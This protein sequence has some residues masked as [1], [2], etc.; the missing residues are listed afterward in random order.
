[1]TARIEFFWDCVSSYTYIASTQIERVAA[2]AGAV[3]VWRPF[4]LG[5]VFKATGN[6]PPAQVRAKG[7]YLFTDMRRW[8]RYYDV[9]V[10]MPDPFPTSTL[11][12]QRVACAAPESGE[13]ARALCR[14]Y[15]G[16]GE[17]VGDQA[18][19]RDCI[20]EV[21]LNADA[22]IAA[23][24]TDEVKQR[25][26]DNT[27][28]AVKRGAFGAPALFVGDELF[29]GCDRFDLLIEHIWGIAT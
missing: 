12:A 22:L 20:A 15:W 11:L 10:R 16:L 25:L 7:R 18:V 14:R 6:A 3:L 8:G 5:A 27:A 13:L 24:A 19:V 17:N 26:K 21:G 4:L 1:M 23:A 28:E 29:W 9:P 2:E